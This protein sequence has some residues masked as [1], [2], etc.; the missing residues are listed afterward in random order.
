MQKLT[1]TLYIA[2]TLVVIVAIP[3]QRKVRDAS[4]SSSAYSCSDSIVEKV[5]GTDPSSY[6]NDDGVEESKL[7]E[8]VCIAA[9]N[10]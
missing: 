3:L 1:V 5:L 6:V 7:S 9:A 2:A 4:A 8:K 10:C